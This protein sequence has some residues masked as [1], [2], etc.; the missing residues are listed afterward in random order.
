MRKDVP[1]VISRVFPWVLWVLWKNKNVFSFEGK[2]FQVDATVNKIQ[3]VCRHWFEV[4]QSGAS[5]QEGRRN[6]NSMGSR[7]R[8]PPSRKLKCN[9]GIA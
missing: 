1:E 6:M 5:S 2:V 7:W 9:V 3:E 4:Q 8:S